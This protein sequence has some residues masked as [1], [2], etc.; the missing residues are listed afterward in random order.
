LARI[1]AN[2]G[3]FEP[4]PVTKFLVAKITNVKIQPPPEAHP[5]WAEALN[6]EFT[7]ID[8]PYADRKAWRN[9]PQSWPTVDKR[10]STILFDLVTAF[11]PAHAVKGDEYDTDNLI[12]KVGQ[13]LM[14]N[15]VDKK[16]EPVL[17]LNGDQRQQPKVFAPLEDAP[18]VAAATTPKAAPGVA[19]AKVGF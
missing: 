12:G 10:G 2:S 17:N 9:V 6:V 16:G 3:N 13:I 4:L 19:G 7:V 14:E 11:D 1:P 8:G 5:T 18:V 15:K